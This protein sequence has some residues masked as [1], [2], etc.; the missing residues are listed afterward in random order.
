M[1]AAVEIVKDADG[2]EALRDE[3]SELSKRSATNEP[4]L[5]RTWV[6]AWW[7][8]FGSLGGRRL[9]ILTIRE[10]GRLIGLVPLLS[11]THWYRPGLPYR[12]LE[13][14]CSGEPQEDEICSDYIGILADE[15]AEATVA[16]AFVDALCDRG[17]LGDWDELVMPS[18]AGDSR[19]PELLAAELRRHGIDAR[20]ETTNHAPYIPLPT[21][22]EAYLDAL[23]SSRRYWLSRSM[24]EVEKLGKV[25]LRCAKTREEL[26]HGRKLL[27]S[28]HGERW[29]EKGNEGG[30]FGSP[31]FRAFHDEVMPQLFDRG[32]LDLLWLVVDEE[33]IAALYNIVWNGK[34]YFYQSGRRLDVPKNVRPGIAIHALAIRRA[35]ELGHR[36]YDFLAGESQY[37]VKLALDRRPL[38][39]LR[40][41][42]SSVRE[43]ARIIS[44]EALQ[45]VASLRNEL[46]ARVTKSI[47]E[48]R[49]TDDS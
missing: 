43:R 15:G 36:E 19:M 33:P 3:W 21:S 17:L 30:V 46:R 48:P 13:L 34:T 20:A 12:R 7:R 16:R 9:R 49:P 27:E 44:A 38:V 26:A 23:P 31:R 29:A 40:A 22:F 41:V 14:L 11:R 6:L 47:A 2:F 25:E 1:M 8:V 32:A 18:M 24:R 39:R 37:K 42:R 4:T 35:I 10:R 28:L 45:Q 5:D